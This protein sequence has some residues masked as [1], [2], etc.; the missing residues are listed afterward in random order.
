MKALR[1]KRG[2][3]RNRKLKFEIGKTTPA[4]LVSF[5]NVSVAAAL[6]EDRGARLKARRPLSDAAAADSP[7]GPQI[8]RLTG[9]ASEPKNSA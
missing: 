5:D 7:Q 3:K 6:G 8:Q 1:F 2:K 9:A 4:P